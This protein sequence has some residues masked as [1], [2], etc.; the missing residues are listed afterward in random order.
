MYND[1]TGIITSILQQL[2]ILAAGDTLLRL[3][4]TL[5]IAAIMTD[6]W[7]TTPFMAL[8][9]LAGLQ[10][11]PQDLYEAASVDGSSRWQQF[12]TIT[13]PMLK[14]SLLIALLFR[15]LDALRVFDLFY[16][17]TGGGRQVQTIA[18]YS[19]NYMF[20]GTT[21]DFAPGLAATVVLFII[22]V[23]VSLIIVPQMSGVIRQD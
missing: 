18:S 6:V 1:Q 16:I 22:C 7:K 4:N 10:V 21:S 17:F 19:Y 5:V 9:L 20:Q 12:W 2:H 15:L 11:I 13:L 3:P 14:N 23:I 8:L